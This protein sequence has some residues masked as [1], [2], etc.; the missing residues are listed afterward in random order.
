M[1]VR[2]I[3]YLN[4]SHQC[5]LLKEMLEVVHLDG[6]WY[7]WKIPG[8]CITFRLQKIEKDMLLTNKKTLIIIC[9]SYF[10]V[11]WVHT[12]T[13]KRPANKIK[14]YIFVACHF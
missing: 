2:E 11:S 4:Q 13:Q 10:A 8:L 12:I 3:Q 6:R 7:I 9:H 1:F 14:G 5:L